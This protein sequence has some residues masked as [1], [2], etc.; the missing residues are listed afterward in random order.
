MHFNVRFSIPLASLCITL[1]GVEHSQQALAFV[2]YVYETSLTSSTDRTRCID[3]PV[4]LL[5]QLS[6][7]SQCH[8]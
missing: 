6:F 2:I 4:P 3:V 5:S 7:V 8:L 1:H